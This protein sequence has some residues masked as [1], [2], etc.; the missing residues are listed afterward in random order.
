MKV[1]GHDTNKMSFWSIKSNLIESPVMFESLEPRILLSGDGLLS[2]IAPP[3]PLL[4][5]MQQ[6]VQN[7]ELLE[8]NE[9]GIADDSSSQICAIPVPD[10]SVPLPIENFSDIPP[11]PYADTFL[12]H[13][14]PGA[15]HTIYLDFDGHV[16]TGTLWNSVWG[17]PS[18][19]TPAYSL[20]GSAAF[21]DTELERIQRIW[22]RVVEDYLPFD[23]DV[24][25][26]DPGTAALINSGGADTQWGVRVCIGG[27]WSDWY[28]SS[29]GG[30]AY[31]GSFNWNT[32]TP[33]FV[34]E[35]A[36]GNG[37]EKYTAEAISHE[38]GHTVG[39][40]HDGN[41]G[42]YYGGYGTGPTGWAPIMGV[43][44]Y[45]ELS[46]WSQGEYPG[47]NNSEDDLN[48]ITTTNGFGYRSDDHGSTLG[49]ASSL[50]MTDGSVS[51][52]GIIERRT[53][54]DYFVF[55]TGAGVINL[56]IDPQYS[57]PNLDILATLYNSAGTPIATSNPT[58]LLDANFNLYLTAGTY[59]ISIDGVGKAAVGT[60]YG[61]SDYGSLG[62][63]S[64]TGTLI[65]PDLSGSFF[66]TVQEPLVAGASFTV[67]Y[68]V[69]N[70]ES[71]AAGG[72][73]V[74]FFLS[75]NSFISTSDYF[76]GAQYI[77][78]LS[79]NSTTG[80]MSVNLILPDASHAFWV[81]NQTYYVGMM[82]DVFPYANPDGM[83]IE[84]NEGN[85]EN[86]GEWIDSDGVYIST[87]PDL[88][89]IWFN[90][91]QEP[92][93]AG[94][95]FTVDFEV[96]NVGPGDAGGFWVDLFLSTDNTITTS[97]Y[98]IGFYWIT[99]LPGNSSTGTLSTNLTL[100]GASDPFY[101][102]NKTY[103]VGMIV[104]RFNSVTEGNENNNASTGSWKDFD[105]VWISNMPD[106]KGSY[107]DTVQE[108]LVAGANF[109]VD[110]KVQNAGPASVGGFWV[111][112]YLSYNSFISTGDYFLG[113][114]WVPSLAG[115][116]TTG[117]LTKSLTLPSSGNP[118]WVGNQVYT[119][120]MIVDAT[121]AITE[122]IETNNANTAQWKDSDGVYVGG[123]PAPPADAEDLSAPSFNIVQEPETNN[124]ST[125]ELTGY[126]EMPITDTAVPIT[127]GTLAYV[128]D[129][130]NPAIT[131]ELDD[132][133]ATPLQSP[134]KNG[135][136]GKKQKS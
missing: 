47:A 20:D 15:S 69:Q 114:Y 33:T 52:E 94:D 48:I 80:T 134:I 123:L 50:G 42:T 62:Y 25:T 61:Y 90:V 18:I 51:D 28:G 91:V 26:E 10:P 87:L 78:G 5:S 59:Y 53:D 99:G 11:Y 71:A 97:D 113:M 84:T 128:N 64:I 131:A 81:G 107:F 77:T 121:N 2:S 119:I 85:N 1:F 63:Y 96:K 31:P 82:V 103:F 127:T 21:S 120:G 133:L 54:L 23:V 83:V 122:K 79:G 124:L 32:D 43:A 38:A 66:N 57:S 126:D 35:D 117:T 45:K 118:F 60:D 73:W 12:L 24:T 49:T 110:F 58:G 27:D 56:D 75:T 65:L 17:I 93:E 101:T 74:D 29:A 14:N 9:Q 6:P 40:G 16:T 7:A 44:Y 30:V 89:G 116:S 34:F 76:L 86:T 46:Q 39:L 36:L 3:D 136:S 104:D 130:N 125:V 115:N 55:T 106:L 100:P 109:N 102:G 135:K 19:V 72:F 8:T 98:L 108:P 13:S 111:D 68:V 67:D 95:T 105:G 41:G 70:T 129:D 132:L 4:D 22:E 37:N 112:F 92:L 88:K